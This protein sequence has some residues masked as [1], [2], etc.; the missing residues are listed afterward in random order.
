MWRRTKQISFFTYW[1]QNAPTAYLL[2]SPLLQLHEDVSVTEQR[3]YLPQWSGKVW[4]SMHNDITQGMQ[5][6]N[7]RM[8]HHR[9]NADGS[10][11][12]T[13]TTMQPIQ[14]TVKHTNGAGDFKIHNDT[15]RVPDLPCSIKT[16][17]GR[18]LLFPVFLYVSSSLYHW[19]LMYSI[20]K[21]QQ[22]KIPGF[23][24]WPHQPPNDKRP[25]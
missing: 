25:H 4:G 3:R 12:Y 22:K 20:H 21:K 7:S 1:S 17:T 11:H 6:M 16:Y 9:I 23:T 19:L 8:L 18:Y 14:N 5:M 10:C 2:I 13:F 24:V 15:F